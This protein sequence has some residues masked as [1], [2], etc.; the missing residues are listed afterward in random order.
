MRLP[1]VLL[2]LTSTGLAQAD[3]QL[4]TEEG[5]AIVLKE[6]ED[7]KAASWSGKCKNGKI[8]GVG[9][10]RLKSG[11]ASDYDVE[12]WSEYKDGLWA[13]PEISLNNVS[14]T[15][16][17]PTR[18]LLNLEECKSNPKC[19]IILQAAFKSGLKPLDPSIGLD[20][21]ALDSSENSKDASSKKST[22]VVDAGKSAKGK[23]SSHLSIINLCN[24][25]GC[26]NTF[27]HYENGQ[28][29][30]V[31]TLGYFSRTNGSIYTVSS[32]MKEC[33]VGWTAHVMGWNQNPDRSASGMVCGAVS[34]ERSLNAA[35]EKCNQAGSLDCKTASVVD[36]QWAY[37]DGSYPADPN[38][39]YEMKSK[40][41]PSSVGGQGG[42][43]CRVY[44]QNLISCA[45]YSSIVRSIGVGH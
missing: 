39:E 21:P 23:P 43:G 20:M 32:E 7:F 12:D 36:M 10:L 18:S 16:N 13:F 35:F 6:G 44:D 40:G 42:G 2:F 22:A 5:C 38:P 9:K 3:T 33:T 27:L 45:E 11:D 26:G 29:P 41:S 1:F 25:S 37:W 15:I 31:I 17:K 14:A 30:Q 19:R 28:D 8:N 34:A 4:K 24:S